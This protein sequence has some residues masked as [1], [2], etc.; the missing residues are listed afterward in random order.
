MADGGGSALLQRAADT[1][2]DRGEG[3]LAVVSRARTAAAGT[4]DGPGRLDGSMPRMVAGQLA[5]RAR[6]DDVLDEAL[7]AEAFDLRRSSSRR[8]RPGAGRLRR[9][10]CARPRPH[11][12][13][14][15]G[16]TLPSWRDSKECLAS[17][18][19]RMLEEG[20]GG[21]SLDRSV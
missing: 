8:S 3:F 2:H 12:L 19:L 5:F 15:P 6:D 16:L 17:R 14:A 10:S 1:D 18:S 4:R 13:S 7:V 9:A 11:G 21:S 20:G